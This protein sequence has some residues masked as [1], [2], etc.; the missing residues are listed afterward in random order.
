MGKT[1][2]A[3]VQDRP[4]LCVM[5]HVGDVEAGL[6]WYEKALI[7]AR[8]A[9]LTEPEYFEYL[10]LGDMQIEIVPA[11]GKVGSGPAGTVAYW[12]TPDFAAT[13]AHLQSLGA[14]LYRGPMRI[15]NGMDMCQVRDPWGNCLGIRGVRDEG[16]PCD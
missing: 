2:P 13:L 15:E 14:T 7:G 1:P 11:D 3:M 6:A 16:S 9:T 10:V 12:H 4:L 8:R 5:I